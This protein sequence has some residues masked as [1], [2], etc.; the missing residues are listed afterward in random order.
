MYI[1][2][3]Y[4]LYII[5]YIQ[6]Y[7][8]IHV[9]FSYLRSYTRSDCCLH[10]NGSCLHWNNIASGRRTNL[11]ASRIINAVSPKQ[12]TSTRYV[13]KVPPGSY[14]CW[15]IPQFLELCSPTWLTMGHHQLVNY[16]PH[17]CPW[18]FQYV[19]IE[20]SHYT[21]QYLTSSPLDLQG[22]VPPNEQYRAFH[23][24]AAGRKVGSRRSSREIQPWNTPVDWSL[25]RDL[26]W[27]NH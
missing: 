9:L 20:F 3:Y 26:T 13:Y 19:L 1:Y 5:Y 4:T 11:Q 2:I 16:I 14:V 7:I 22:S 10:H 17:I 12:T 6:I 27:F 23:P 18:Y 25:Y 8:Y 15:F 24:A 21:L